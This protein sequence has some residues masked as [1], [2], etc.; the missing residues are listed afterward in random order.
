MDA[1]SVQEACGIAASCLLLA[2]VLRRR[3]R[4]LSCTRRWWVC[5]Y[6]SGRGMNGDFKDYQEMRRT[7]REL[8]FKYVRMSPRVFDKLLALVV[9]Y[10]KSPT[11]YRSRLR[12]QISNAEK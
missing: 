2:V 9:P 10:L 4:L 3:R 1:A 5:P 12:A 8:H 11:R 7:D 6:F